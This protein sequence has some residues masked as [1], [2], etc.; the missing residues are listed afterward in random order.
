MIMD[1]LFEYATA[2][3]VAGSRRFPERPIG[4]PLHAGF[5]EP[6]GL[7]PLRRAS[8]SDGFADHAWDESGHL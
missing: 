8:S 6:A 1:T 5:V 7:D 4:H 3:V 2:D